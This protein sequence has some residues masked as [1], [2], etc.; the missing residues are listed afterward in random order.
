[1]FQ[2]SGRMAVTSGAVLL[3]DSIFLFFL[4]KGSSVDLNLCPSLSDMQGLPRIHFPYFV[5]NSL[6]LNTREDK[7]WF[8]TE[9]NAWTSLSG[10]ARFKIWICICTVPVL[11][12]GLE[13][14]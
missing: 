13:C 14:N 5:L 1:M 2:F 10:I 12:P 3:Y 4:S 6:H 11:H 7:T 8:E 9:E